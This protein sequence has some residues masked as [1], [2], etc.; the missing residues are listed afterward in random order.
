M[1][2]LSRSPQQ[3]ESVSQSVPELSLDVLPEAWRTAL[4]PLLGR[5]QELIQGA[6][7]QYA[8]LSQKYE[9][10]RE[11]AQRLDRE[12]EERNRE[13]EAALQE[14]QRLHHSLRSIV[15][16]LHDGVIAVDLEGRVTLFNRRAAELTGKSEEEV[17]GQRYESCFPEHPPI[18]RQ[19]LQ[20]KRPHVEEFENYLG[21]HSRRQIE[22][23]TALVRDDQD[24]VLGAVEV[25]RDMTERREMEAQLQRARVLAALGEVAVTIAHEI[26]NPLGAIQLRA[27]MLRE[28]GL[29]PQE[30]S[31][32]YDTIFSAI[33]LMDTTIANLL[34]FSRPKEMDARYQNLAPLLDQ[35][36]TLAEH[37]IRLHHVQVIRDYPPLG[38][39]AQVD[40]SQFLKA[41]LN[42][43]LNAVQAMEGSPVRC[44][45]L[46]AQRQEGDGS[47]SGPFQGRPWVEIAVADTGCGIPPEMVEKVFTPFFT[48][49]D[50]GVGLGLPI[51][52]NIVEAHGGRIR[53][54][55]QPGEGTTFRLILPVYRPSRDENFTAA[56]N[57][58]REEG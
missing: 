18:L 44:L 3:Q 31:R 30:Q 56:G 11:Q 1:A 5:L 16:S 24:Q 26:R 34:Q 45:R 58:E 21:D 46:S 29:S 54:E 12:L 52:H 40:G 33:K 19:T 49:K 25:L 43:L 37:A 48:T 13:L 9:Q 8:V 53:V 10:L 41:V 27:E 15:N 57:A 51:V 17:L 32:A 2:E 6:E 47:N 39:M 14:Q 4:A 50:H 36:L 55:S 20:E 42:L 22:V 38:L 7:S 28:G 35:A 23:T